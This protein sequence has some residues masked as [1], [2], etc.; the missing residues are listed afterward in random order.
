MS[1][2]E[3]VKQ[4]GTLSETTLLDGKIING[5]LS[6]ASIQDGV[7]IDAASAEQLVA[8]IKEPLST[9]VVDTVQSEKLTGLDIRDLDLAGNV[10]L[11]DQAAKTIVEG[12]KGPLKEVIVDVVQTEELTGVNIRGIEIN[13]SVALDEQAARELVREAK[14][15]LTEAV[16]AT[17]GTEVVTDATLKDTEL[18]GNVVL[19]QAAAKDIMGYLSADIETATVDT[20]EGHEFNS[21]KTDDLIVGGELKM[22]HDTAS[23]VAD[24]VAEHLEDHVKN[25]IDGGTFSD[26]T[27]DKTGLTG[28]V[29]TDVGAAETL[30]TSIEGPLKRAVKAAVE[31]Q[32]LDGLSLT[33]DMKLDLDV[34]NAI[35]KAIEGAVK[36]AATEVAKEALMLDL[37]GLKLVA[38][39]L[40]G[41]T[42]KGLTFE[43]GA[44]IDEVT[45]KTIYN[46]IRDMVDKDIDTA[47]SRAVNCYLFKRLGT[48]LTAVETE[49]V[50][51]GQLDLQEGD[52][53]DF[54]AE[55]EVGA[56]EVTLSTAVFGE[57]GEPKE[58]TKTSPQVPVLYSTDGKALLGGNIVAQPSDLAKLEK[59]LEE[60]INENDFDLVKVIHREEIVFIGAWSAESPLVIAGLT[61]VMELPEGVTLD[62]TESTLMMDNVLSTVAFAVVPVLV[63][64][65]ADNKVT[66][67]RKSSALVAPAG[68]TAHCPVIIP[69]GGAV[70]FNAPDPRQNGGA[71]QLTKLILLTKNTYKVPKGSDVL[72]GWGKQEMV[73]TYRIEDDSAVGWVDFETYQGMR[74]KPTA[75]VSDRVATLSKESTATNTEGTIVVSDKDYASYA[76]MGTAIKAYNTIADNSV[77]V[78]NEWIAVRDINMA[79]AISGHAGSLQ[80]YMDSDEA[81]DGVFK[82]NRNAYVSAVISV[83]QG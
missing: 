13:G 15:P 74:K 26:V 7:T 36:S 73:P 29:T 18:L 51:V 50:I 1:C 43:G 33:G 77:S 52:K 32:S 58:V 55:T 76:D 63:G 70:I 39:T 2:K 27:L 38:T 62:R 23:G 80:L 9:A 14:K 69:E 12:S 82:D 67:T 17:L 78:V 75:W 81:A 61:H 40:Q 30:V 57:E 65:D 56:L 4:G 6:G 37:N 71:T 59:A 60:K 8:G 19:G 53:L 47:V 79:G 25:M 22:S 16:V 44:I 66:T 49:K 41:G 20:V 83:F 42:A 45:A 11:D 64:L 28:S 72:A 68:G 5:E 21:L 54:M 46:A 31:G 48:Y 10:K 3:I 34:A 24:S 35:F